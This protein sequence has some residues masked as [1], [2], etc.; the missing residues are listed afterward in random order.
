M[1]I[2][3]MRTKSKMLEEVVTARLGQVSRVVPDGS[4]EEVDIC[5]GTRIMAGRQL[6][7]HLGKGR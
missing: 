7:K 4:S 2:C 5:D 3:A 1:V 6:C